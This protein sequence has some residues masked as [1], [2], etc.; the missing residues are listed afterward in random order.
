VE[1]GRAAP[2]SLPVAAPASLSRHAALA[3]AAGA[4]ALLTLSMWSRVHLPGIPYNLAKLFGEHA[5]GGAAVFSLALLWLGGGVWVAAHAVLRLEARRRQGALWLPLLL[6]G[7]AL[8]SFVL[9]DL[10]TPAIMLDKIIGAPDL[11]RRIVEGN[12]WGEAWRAAFAPWPRAVVEQGERLVRY[13]GL[14]SVFMIPLAA[15]LLGVPR[16]GRGARLALGIA[17]LLPCWVLAKYVVLDWAITDN[18]TELVVEGGSF[19]LAGAL[20]LF[21]ANAATLVAY[22]GRPRT[23]AVLA[24]WTLALAGASWW[25]FGQAI[26]SVVINNGRVFN[27]VQFLL[28][29]NRTELLSEWALFG[30]WCA[31][32]LGATAVVVGGVLLAMRVLP[33]PRAPQP[34]RPA[35]RGASRART[36]A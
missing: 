13:V 6:A 16:Q 2:A 19:W 4:A 28:G 23:F 1:R 31:L 22:A 26:E 35:R 3:P 29:E 7:I 9:V 8:V 36:P 5:L 33:A 11:Y 18:L 12:Y 21:A 30:R 20:A 15:S 10:A 17:C 32:Y 24:G 14:Y 27:G 34:V 25:L